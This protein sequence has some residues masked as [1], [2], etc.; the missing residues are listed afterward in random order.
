VGDGVTIYRVG[1]APGI[2][3]DNR[4]EA[5]LVQAIRQA[6]KRLKAGKL[7]LVDYNLVALDDRTLYVEATVSHARATDPRSV[8]VRFEVAVSKE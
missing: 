2:R 4:E 3:T 1:T 7:T 6:R 8:T 5:I